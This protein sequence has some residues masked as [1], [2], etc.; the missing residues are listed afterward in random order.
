MPTP[1]IRFV[2]S[3]L[4]IVTCACSAAQYGE[5]RPLSP[6][7]K[8]LV[9][10]HYLPELETAKASDYCTS[11]TAT[12][13]DCAKREFL[14]RADK[15]EPFGV[16]RV[17][18]GNGTARTS[19]IAVT[20]PVAPPTP[21]A[22]PVVMASEPE[23]ALEPAPAPTQPESTED[24]VLMVAAADENL[25]TFVRLLDIAGLTKTIQSAPAVTLLAPTNEALAKMPNLAKDKQRLRKVLSRHVVMEAVSTS[26]APEASQRPRRLKPLAGQPIPMRTGRDGVVT[27]GR[28]KVVRS[29][30]S[31]SRGNVEVID[32]VLLP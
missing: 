28:A 31:T 24:D 19:A 22:A 27:I 10:E 4:A 16:S 11:L 6:C 21:V 29:G 32:A 20:A 12:Q 23:P 13:L 7:A 5:R 1:P 30:A 3:T 2:A 26:D 15:D 8:Q 18:A 14:A 9:D 17:C 25:S